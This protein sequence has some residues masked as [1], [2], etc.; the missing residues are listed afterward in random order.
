MRNRAA[1]LGVAGLAAGA[2]VIAATLA[3]WAVWGWPGDMGPASLFG[4]GLSGASRAPHPTPT[5]T[6]RPA[7]PGWVTVLDD[8]FTAPGIPAHWE[9]YD[10]PY[11]SGPENCAAPSQDSAPGDGYLYL[12]MAYRQG[13]NCGAGWYTGGMMISDAY[14]L[15]EQAI[16]V[17]WRVLPSKHPTVVFSHHIIPMAFPDD[18]SYQWYQAEADYCEAESYTGC[19]TYLHDGT[20]SD[21]SG[22]HYNDYQNVNLTK[23]HA[24]RFVQAHGTLKA[25]IDDMSKPVWVFNGG[26][27]QFP[28]AIRRAVLQQECP[29]DACPPASYA[30]ATE[31]IQIDWITIQIPG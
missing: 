7:P 31:T 6:I 28:N 26:T 5:A 22:Q 16:T 4:R 29:A 21:T 17:R 27:S 12:T 23:W 8:E 14:A 2:L 30:G 24:W 11:G 9:L 20:A 19:W 3:S 13:G 1:R 18:P 10:A 25:Y 15:R